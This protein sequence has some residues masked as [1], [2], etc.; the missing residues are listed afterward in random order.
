MSDANIV[1]DMVD[2]E[3]RFWEAEQFDCDPEVC[4]TCA[5]YWECQ[6]ALGDDM[7]TTCNQW[8]PVILGV[9]Q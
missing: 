1:A 9:V 3:L 6:S 7:P 5:L 4:E 2:R 8:R